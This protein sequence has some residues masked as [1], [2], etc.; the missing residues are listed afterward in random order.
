MLYELVSTRV[1][2]VG[3]VLY[4]LF[5]VFFTTWPL[6]FH[7]DLRAIRDK[8]AE[9][10]WVIFYYSSNG[11]I[12][13]DHDLILNIFFF[14]PLGV[15]WALWIRPKSWWWAGLSALLVG[16]ALSLFV[17]GLQVLTIDRTTQLADVWRNALGAGLAGLGFGLLRPSS[18]P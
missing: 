4:S 18:S 1:A 14:M 2:R 17:E 8:W 13:V 15:L 3:F 9:T 11:S 6:N 16:L 7:F 5:V 12:I 10:E